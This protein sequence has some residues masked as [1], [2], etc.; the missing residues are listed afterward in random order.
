VTSAEERVGHREVVTTSSDGVATITLH[1]PARKNAMSVAGWAALRDA[2][3][4]IAAGQDRVLVLTGAGTDFCSGADL[5]AGGSGQHPLVDMRLAAETCLAL[6]ELPIPTIA[7][8]DGVAVGAGMNI[9]LA[10]DFV[11]ATVRARFCEIFIKR[12]LSVDFGGSWILPRLIGLHR[13]KQLVLLGDFVG[14]SAADRMGLLYQLVLVDGLDEAVGEL[15]GRLTSS[16]A[17]AVSLS[18]RLL[19]ESFH[20][21]I[22][23]AL[24]DEGRAQAINLTSTDA[25]EA[26]AAFREKR[27]PVFRGR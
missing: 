23:R 19:N 26:L 11:I 17:L 10:C 22:V 24:D 16:P 15:A 4:D 1:N 2:L 25:A 9:A 8:V 18:K 7:R 3:R 5:S 6:Y 27:A 20:T 21:S 12:G 13:A 14:A